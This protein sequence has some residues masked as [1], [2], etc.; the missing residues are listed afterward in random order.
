MI[1]VGPEDFEPGAEI[2]ALGP[3]GA[4]ATFIGHVRGDDEL[5]ALTLEHYPA[6]ATRALQILANEAQSRWDL[7]AVGIV[8]RVG[9]LLPGERIVF[10]GTAAPHRA[11]ALDACA[12]LIDELKT[13]APFWKSEAFAKGARWLS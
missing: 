1:R 12:Y 6:M 13:R 5:I 10:V 7:T 8:H 9:R 2:A 11:A 4:V 3:S